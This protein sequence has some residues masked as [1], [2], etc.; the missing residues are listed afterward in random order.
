MGN[1]PPPHRYAVVWTSSSPI[2][3][4]AKNLPH[5]VHLLIAGNNLLLRNTRTLWAKRIIYLRICQI[6]NFRTKRILNT[7]NRR[8]NKVR[9]KRFLNTRNWRISLFRAKRSLHLRHRRKWRILS[10]IWPTMKK[11][12]VK[13]SIDPR[14]A[15]IFSIIPV[16]QH[17][18]LSPGEFRL[19]AAFIS[20]VA[21][22]K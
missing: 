3:L 2:F 6:R 15:P 11:T 17:Y 13:I 12:N 20:S 19:C 9:T 8:Y 22:A 1:C 5:W 4:M 18:I 10:I 21:N 7:S 14:S 16:N